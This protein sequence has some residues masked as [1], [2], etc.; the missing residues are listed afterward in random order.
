MSNKSQK[1]PPSIFADMSDEEVVLYAQKSKDARAQ[2]YIIKKYQ[3][4]AAIKSKEYFLVGAEREDVFQEGMIGLYKAIRDFRDDRLASFK[5]FAEICVTRQVLTAIKGANRQKHIPLNSYVSFSKPLF[6]NGST[7]TMMDFTC[8]KEIINPEEV[9]L[10]KEEHKEIEKNLSK[11]L[12]SFEWDVLHRY[13]VGKSYVEI[14]VEMHRQNKAIDNA[15]Q[16]VKHKME[17][18]MPGKRNPLVLK[19]ILEGAYTLQFQEKHYKK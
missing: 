8:N 13:L 12:S 7:K 19:R 17:K 2:E 10:T 14:A 3:K 16:R 15:L 11:M 6:T 9:L 5:A 1:K 4:I 18:I